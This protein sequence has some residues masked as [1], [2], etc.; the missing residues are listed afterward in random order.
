MKKA[1]IS[2]ALLLPIVAWAA[3]VV[4]IDGIYYSFTKSTAIV[5]APIDGSYS[6]DITIPDHVCYYNWNYPVRTI[7][8]HAF[9][10]CPDLTSVTLPCTLTAISEQAFYGCSSLESIEIP[11]SVT[12]IGTGAFLY[13]P[14]LK[15]VVVHQ[16]TPLPITSETFTDPKSATLYVPFGCKQAYDE[17]D[18]WTDF[19][20][21]YELDLQCATP[22][23]EFDNG[24]V[25]FSCETE[26]VKYISTISLAGSQSY[27]DDAVLVTDMTPA[28]RV[29][30]YAKKKDY[31]DSEP[32]INYYYFK[33]LK[34]DTNDD[35]LVTIS[36]AV[37]IV[38]IILNG[39]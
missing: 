20:E 18:Y 23:I 29:S 17:A 9:G 27:T 36:D 31:I 37:D 33:S 32:A 12:Y 35:G 1:L 16:K 3:E 8:E 13:C 15:K 6:G 5:V 24:K 30:V 10:K 38:N 19:K 39:Y 22:T 34:G 7:G 4:K 11:G 28:Y 2:L 26:G 25:T 21:I 14:N